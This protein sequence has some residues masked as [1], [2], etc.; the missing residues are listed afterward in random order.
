MKRKI[1]FAPTLILIAIFAFSVAI[2]WVNIDRPLSKHHEFVTGVSL[3]IIQIWY[4]EGAANFKYNPSMNYAGTPNKFINNHASTTGTMLDEEGN[5]YYIS[6]PPLAYLFPY[7]VFKTIKVRP[8]IRSLQIFHLVINFFS[9]YFIYLIICLLGQQRP[10]GKVYISGIVGFLVYLFNPAVLWFQANTYMSDMLVHVFFIIGVYIMLKLL[11]RKRFFSPKYLIYYA[12]GLFLMIYTS[13]LGLFFAFAVF[14]YSMIKL[15]YERVF[16]PLVFITIAVTICTLYLIFYQYSQING[17]EAYL[18]QMLNRLGERG[19]TSGSGIFGFLTLK[20][21]ELKRIIINYG[22]LYLPIFLLLVTF[23][24]Q[25]FKGPKLRIVFTKNGYR[26]LWFS[27]LPILLLHLF[28]LG[29]SGHNFTSL[30]G[31]LFLSVLVAI[32]YDK[33]RQSEA[34]S[35]FQA[36]LGIA[37][38]MVLSIGIY[39]YINLPGSTS[40]KRYE[41]AH[42]QKLGLEVKNTIAIDEVAFWQGAVSL[43]PQVVIYAERNIKEITSPEDAIEFLNEHNLKKGRIYKLQPEKGIIGIEVISLP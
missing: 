4:D 9:A 11:I 10:F 6:H 37:V 42:D 24:L 16:L 15:R 17:V 31:S 43:T 27:T 30:Y 8:T 28:L 33:L 5:Y 13:W 40:V 12:V 18:T 35:K 3:R 41:Y 26:F 29:Y 38:V 7:V 1:N 22:I 25:V 21:H 2:R 39:F 36:N 23:G 34:L 19:S 20:F 14:L 32:L